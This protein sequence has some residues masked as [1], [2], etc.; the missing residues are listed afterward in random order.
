MAQGTADEK[1]RVAWLTGPIGR[2]LVELAGPMDLT[3]EPTAEPGS[4]TDVD[5]APA[6]TRSSAGC[7]SS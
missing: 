4:E 3:V 7:S 5:P 6:S 2:E 1:I